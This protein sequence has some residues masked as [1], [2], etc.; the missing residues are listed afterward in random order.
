MGQLKR[1]GLFSLE[2]LIMICLKTNRYIFVIFYLSM[3]WVFKF[4]SFDLISIVEYNEI[5]LIIMISEVTEG[6]KISVKTSYESQFSSPGHNMYLFSYEI[7]IENHNSFPV[8]LLT[9]HWFITDSMGEL[10][11]SLIHI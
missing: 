4:I 6:V 3:F 9:R 7:F 10:R 2:F 8:Q 11:L 5:N 1:V